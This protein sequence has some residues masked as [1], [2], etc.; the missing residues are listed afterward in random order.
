MEVGEHSPH[1]KTQQIHRQALTV[2]IHAH[3]PPVRNCK[4][5]EK[6]S[7]YITETYN[8]H[9]TRVQNTALYING[10]THIKQHRSKGVQPNVPPARTITV[11]LD[12]STH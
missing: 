4:T 2:L 5:M 11:S 12:M 8:T 6:S 7:S 9:A 10:T 3:I 1:L